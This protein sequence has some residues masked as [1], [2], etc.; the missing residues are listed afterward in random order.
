MKSVSR[1]VMGLVLIVT[2]NIAMAKA[3]CQE[4]LPKII[5]AGE[6][7]EKTQNPAIKD[8]MQ[9][10][11]NKILA[12]QDEN[13]KTAAIEKFLQGLNI[14]ENKPA[15]SGKD[16]VTMDLNREIEAINMLTKYACLLYDLEGKGSAFVRK[17]LVDNLNTSGLSKETISLLRQLIAVLDEA[18]KTLK[19]IT[20]VQEDNSEE[21]A[22]MWANSVG[23]AVGVSLAIGDPTPLIAGVVNGIRGQNKLD[24]EKNR[25]LTLFIQNHQSRI[26]N[27]LFNVNLRRSELE[28]TKNVNHN[29]FITKENYDAF[30]AAL[31]MEDKSQ[32]AAALNNCYS[33]CPNLREALYYLFVVY[34]GDRNIGEAEKYCLRLI[35]YPS[36]ILRNDG[37]L[38]VAYYAVSC[39]RLRSGKY[40]EAVDFATRVLKYQ[41]NFDMAYNRRGVAYIGLNK[42]D[43]ASEDIEKAIQLDPSNGSHYW[44][45]SALSAYINDEDAALSFLHLAVQFGFC[46][47]KT[48]TGF[49]PIQKALKSQRGKAI[50]KPVLYAKYESGIL[51]D[52]IIVYNTGTYTLTNVRLELYLT[53]PDASNPGNSKSVTA[54]SQIEAIAVNDG[55]KFVDSL[56]ISADSWCSIR[57]R[58]TCDQFPGED[59]HYE[60]CYNYSSDHI[61][62]SRAEY[63]NQYA[64]GVF[65]NKQKQLYEKAYAMASD[66][67]ALTYEQQHNCLDT[68]AR[69]AYELGKI[70]EARN[71]ELEAIKILKRD[72]RQDAEVVKQIQEYES[73]LNSFKQSG[74]PNANN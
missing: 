8:Y 12:I 67:V 38:G 39:Y 25:T 18:E 33:L 69:L 66:A 74:T 31:V 29:L 10:E 63:N 64:W 44:V 71:L 17:E 2:F 59:F 46:D 42:Y 36:R 54:S 70:E 26:T 40:Q 20:Y 35:E 6:I 52:D 21:S 30:K 60:F 65:S 34:D 49:T 27:F 15:A 22:E 61:T 4:S 55:Y 23:G 24:K 56:S 43:L 72:Y 32:K 62:V 28:E 16:S 11:L 9:K 7:I 53:Y 50:L 5:A 68:K 13:S 41:P 51:N 73:A 3:Q 37:L 58:M 57:I 45:A 14:K 19:S 47:F 1:F 48:V